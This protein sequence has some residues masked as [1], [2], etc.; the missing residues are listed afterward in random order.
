MDALCSKV[1]ATG[2]REKE[3]DSNVA[4]LLMELLQS[5]E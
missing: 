2:K 3:R 4:L 5:D 1:G